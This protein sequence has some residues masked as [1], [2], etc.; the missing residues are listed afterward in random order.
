MEIL[1]KRDP[2]R[3]ELDLH[4]SLQKNLVLM[5]FDS[6]NSYLLECCQLFGRIELI[7]CGVFFLVLAEFKSSGL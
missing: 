2:F 3:E 6:L 1:L 7:S 4:S 5:T